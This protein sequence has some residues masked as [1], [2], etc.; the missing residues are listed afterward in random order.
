MLS[1]VSEAKEVD[2][3]A[4]SDH[5][6]DGKFFN[7]DPDSRYTVD[8]SGVVFALWRVL[9]EKSKEARPQ[10]SNLIPVIK[11]SR[12][13]L[14][15][16]PDYSVIR[17]VHSTLLFKLEG[18]FWLTDPMF[19]D[20]AS[21]VVLSNKRFHDLPITI[22]ELPTIE[23]VILSHNHYD[24]LDEMSIKALRSKTRR[25]FVPL[26]LGEILVRFGVEREKIVE[27]DWWQSVDHGAFELVATPAQHF[28]GRG[29]FDGGK[30]LWCSWV[31][32]APEA[33]LY[34]SGDGGYFKGYKAI[35][36]KYG[37][38]DMTFIEAGGYDRDWKSMHMMP[39]ESIQAH[40][41][42]NGKIMVPIHNGSFDMALHSW[43]EPLDSVLSAANEK[44]AT[45]AFPKMGEAIS[46][47]KYTKLDKWW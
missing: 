37:P 41:D 33:T 13:S 6:K 20:D 27:L 12:E 17:L 36:E 46:V 44:N 32:R 30:T 39:I 24:H 10:N 47:L 8:F 28:S 2:V 18:T 16:L 22:D 40:L 21:P 3:T 26:G 25:F 43:V 42:L 29:V 14:E 9:F 34:F 31:I 4:S 23:G 38:F 5:Y 7:V 15:R 1:C 45:V 35:G 19:S 11:Q